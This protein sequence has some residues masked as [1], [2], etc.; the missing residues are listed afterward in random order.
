MNVRNKIVLAVVFLLVAASLRANEVG[1]DSPLDRAEVDRILGPLSLTA[2]IS[3]ASMQILFE[4][5]ESQYRIGLRSQALE[6]FS[7]IL[8]L[9][10][11]LSKAWLRIGN[12]HHQSGRESAAIDAYQ[13]AVLHAGA[14]EDQREAGNKALLNISMLYLQKAAEALSV[15]EKAALEES[16]EKPIGSPASRRGELDRLLQIRQHAVEVE[17]RTQLQADRLRTTGKRRTPGAGI[18]TP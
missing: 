4:E 9:S 2:E 13:H 5:A 6:A 10:P 7:A 3:P 18:S 16:F 14:A 15:L 8:S 1:F 11:R 17:T 12:L